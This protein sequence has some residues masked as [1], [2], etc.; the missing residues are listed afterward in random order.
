MGIWTVNPDGTH[1]NPVT[2]GSD[3]FD[4]AWSPDGTRIAFARQTNG[5]SAIWIVDAYGT[6]A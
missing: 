6:H 2:H 5:P 1:L 4:P 3:D